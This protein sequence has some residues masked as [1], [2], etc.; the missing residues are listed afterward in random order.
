MIELNYDYTQEE[1]LDSLFQ[2]GIKKGDSVFIHSNIGFFGAL[3]NANNKEEYYQSFKKALSEALGKE[4]TIIVPTFSYSFCNKEGFN[5]KT[6]KGVCGVFSEQLRLDP[7]AFR[8]EDANFSVAAVGRLASFFTEDAPEFSFGPGS[9]WDKFLKN[10]GIFCNFNFDAAST[11]IHYV[12]RTL[13][14]P[15][16]YDKPFP[17]II[18]NSEGKAEKRVFYHF[19]YDLNTPEL[20]ANFERFSSLVLEK[21]IATTSNLG[22]GQITKI[23]AENV[24]DF[25]E[26]QIKSEPYFLTAKGR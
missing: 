21:N 16:R 7:E 23:S 8:S 15:Y 26:T 12:E 19:V 11:F 22:K 10:K 13:K 18:V 5:V 14:V 3:K 9:F 17:G 25:I 4:G 1:I 2:C 20:I 24:Y 6:T